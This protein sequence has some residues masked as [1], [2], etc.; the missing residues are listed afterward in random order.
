MVRWSMNRQIGRSLSGKL[1]PWLID[2]LGAN[3]AVLWI[4]GT[5]LLPWK[6]EESFLSH[7]IKINSLYPRQSDCGL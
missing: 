7:L 5:W 6:F 2:W 3:R 4:F 1:S